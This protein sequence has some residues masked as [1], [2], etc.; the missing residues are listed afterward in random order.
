MANAILFRVKCTVNISISHEM[1]V[2]TKK[3]KVEYFII[4]ELNEILNP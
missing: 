3:T 1:V 2:E 4:I